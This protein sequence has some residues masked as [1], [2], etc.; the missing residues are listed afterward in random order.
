MKRSVLYSGMIASILLGGIQSS[1]AQKP[2]GIDFFTQV[3]SV[4][5]V[6][7][8]GNDVWVGS[9]AIILRKPGMH[10]GDGAIIGAG[11]VVTKSVEPYAIVAGTP[12]RTIGSRFSPEVVE[13]LLRLRWWDWDDERILAAW[14]LLSGELDVG[15]LDEL[16]AFVR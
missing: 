16:E 3:R 9:G 4:S 13:R 5:N 2:V 7:T 8:I 15:V 12:A 11:A 10:I 1:V 6:K 14:P